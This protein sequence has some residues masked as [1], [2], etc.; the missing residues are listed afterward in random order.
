M[1]HGLP[2]SEICVM[3]EN[4]PVKVIVCP[5]TKNL[6]I[7]LV[8]GNVCTDIRTYV[9]FF[10]DAVV[11]FG[12]V[13]HTLFMKTQVSRCITLLSQICELVGS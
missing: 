4:G 9:A 11:D 1:L 5:P 7:E 6:G 12:T 8:K 2:F 3:V 13:I 10:E